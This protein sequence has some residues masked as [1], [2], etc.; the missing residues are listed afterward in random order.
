MSTQAAD[1]SRAL[2]GPGLAA[3]GALLVQPWR[4]LQHLPPL[5]WLQPEPA[6]VLLHADGSR[7][8]WLGD[9][10]REGATPAECAAARF[11]A[12]EVPADETLEC[13]VPLPPMP[14]GDREDAI[15]LAVRTTSP[16]DAAELVWG[17][18]AVQGGAVA[19]LSTRKAVQA[20]LDAVAASGARTGTPE[21]WALDRGARPVVLQGFGESARRRLA[22]RGRR[23]GGLLLLG[24]LLL[25]LAVLLTPTL[26]L[27]LRALQAQ[28]AYDQAQQ[29]L[30]PVLAQREALAQAQ[31]QQGALHEQ[32]QARVEPLAVLDLLTQAVPDDSFVQRL[33]LQGDKLTLTGQTPNTAALM[34]RL[35]AEPLLRDVRSPAAATRGMTAGRENF[36]LEMNLQ[37]QAL[38][39]A[40]SAVEPSPAAASLAVA[41]PASASASAVAVAA[42][43]AAAREPR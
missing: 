43:A 10:R 16:F 6:V 9:R 27:R 24:A 31:A 28:Q 30:A 40:A 4:E 14:E 8:L 13:A 26:Q 5:S 37:P 18:R 22:V 17:W 7:S 32:M 2:S 35:S 39:P 34:N 12:V 36:T 21:A 41:T 33:Q 29:R 1:A 19:L 11:V 38:R 25:A 23:L 15:A 20:R 42:S 3:L